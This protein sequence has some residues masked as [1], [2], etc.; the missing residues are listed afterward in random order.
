LGAHLRA[1]AGMYSRVHAAPSA[2]P[3]AV[4]PQPSDQRFPHRPAAHP[5]LRAGLHRRHHDRDPAYPLPL[6]QDRRQ[7]GRRQRPRPVGGPR[8]DHRRPDLLRHHHPR[9][10][11]AR[12]VRRVR[13]V[14]RR[15]RHLGRR[16]ARRARGRLAAAQVGPVRRAVRQRD[17]ARPAARA[18]RRADRQLL[19]QRALRQADLPALGPGR[20][21]G[22]PAGRVPAVRHLPAV[23]PVRADL[24]HRVCPV[25]HLAGQPRADQVLGPVRALRGRLLRVPHLRGDHPD[26]LLGVLLRPAAQ[27]VRRDRWHPRR[28]HLVRHRAA[29]PGK[30]GGR[31]VPA[32]PGRGRRR[33]CP[34]RRERGRPSEGRAAKA[35]EV[36]ATEATIEASESST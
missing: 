24:G 26:R 12:L 19:Q 2:C 11:P 22:F 1:P 29:P 33:E 18:G 31:P 27:H 17:R 30:A 7:P 21:A 3:A 6:A 34:G 13:G 32:A 9:R 36:E 8:R 23:V 20:P 35:S 16:A 4:Y 5:L 28:A 15:A 14:D 10:H 25:P